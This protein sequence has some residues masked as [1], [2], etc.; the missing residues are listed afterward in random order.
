MLP[1]RCPPSWLGW[2]LHANGDG[3]LAGAGLEVALLAPLAR[4]LQGGPARASPWRAIVPG[5]DL[6]W[7][8]VVFLGKNLAEGH[9]LLVLT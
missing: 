5:K 7:G 1:R 9:S 4:A 3:D 6:A 2:Q 8:L